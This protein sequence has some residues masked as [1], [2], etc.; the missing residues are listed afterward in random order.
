MPGTSPGPHSRPPR[1]RAARWSTP[2]TRTPASRSSRS[3]STA[4]WWSTRPSCSSRPTSSACRSSGPRWRRP[5]RWARPT[6][7]GSR[8]GSGTAWTTCATTGP[9]T[10]AGSRPWTTPSAKSS[11]STGRRRSPAP[12]TGSSSCT[13]A[14]DADHRRGSARW[15]TR[16]VRS[17]ET[18][19]L[20]IG[21]GATGAGVLWD[22]ALR[23]FDTV[24][25]ERGDLAEGTS[26]RFHGLLHSGGRYVVKDPRA[27]DEC[28]RE[29]VVLRRIAADCIEDT[30]GLFVT[31][32]DD[33]PDLGE[34][35]VAVLAHNGVGVEVPQQG[36]C[37]LPLQ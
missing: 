32:P 36:C 11:T 26:G 5:R 34:R 23:G 35:T 12:S 15:H 28:V 16:L 30:G 20:V 19:V 29:N 10:S 21:G 1:S 4:A 27:A 14:D 31:T 24:L 7:P 17:L 18:E 8:R 13:D 25:V 9:K 3:R 6:P 37:G 22:C 2:R 33:D